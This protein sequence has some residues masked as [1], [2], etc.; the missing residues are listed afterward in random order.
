MRF[1][2]PNAAARPPPAAILEAEH[3]AL[4]SGAQ[5]VRTFF[6]ASMAGAHCAHFRA[7]SG[8]RRPNRWLP[9]SPCAMQAPGGRF[10]HGCGGKARS[11]TEK[12]C[13]DFARGDRQ[14]AGWRLAP[15]TG[16]GK[17][18]AASRHD[19]IRARRGAGPRPGRRTAIAFRRRGGGTSAARWASA[20]KMRPPPAAATR[21][22]ATRSIRCASAHRKTARTRWPRPSCWC[23]RAGNEVLWTSP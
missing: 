4:K 5:D 6:T 10:R 8:C 20:P 18:A 22:K 15:C 17:S 1:S 14:S 13:R 2:A 9:I 3:A 12:S 16:C 23:A 11:L 7:L 21:W 19:T